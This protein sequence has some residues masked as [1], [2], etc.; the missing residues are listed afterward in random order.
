MYEMSRQPWSIEPFR[1]AVAEDS[2]TASLLTQ[3]ERV[4]AAG[5]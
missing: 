2:R 1:E 5:A 3:A 4:I